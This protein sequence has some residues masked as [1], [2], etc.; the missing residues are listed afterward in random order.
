MSARTV[1]L[2]LLAFVAA[3][4]T[5]FYARHWLN[6]ERAAMQASAR[7]PAVVQSSAEM[8]LVAAKNLPAG[9]FIKA[10]SMKWQA[11][12]KSGVTDAYA[13]EGKRNEKDFIGA[14]ARFAIT[15]GEPLTDARLVHPGDRGFLAAVLEPGKRAVSVPVNATTGIAGFVFPGDWVDVLLSVRFRPTADEGKTDETRYFSETLLTDV[16]VLAIDQTVD[17]KKGQAAVAKTATLEVNPKQAEKVALGLEMGTLSLSLHSLAR[18]QDPFSVAARKAGADPTETAPAHSYT[19]DN[20]IFYMRN[21]L[22]AALGKR[23][24]KQQVNVLRGSNATTAKF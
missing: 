8:V 1:I 15:A 22:L 21:D 20:D 4:F 18:K 11:W 19:M 6:S 24:A 10:D 13:V 16:R 12:P 9:T 23:K 14:V 3:A 7:R 5:A 2:V 17:N